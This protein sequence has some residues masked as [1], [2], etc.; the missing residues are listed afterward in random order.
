M[1]ESRM[2]LFR[3]RG[4]G[5]SLQIGRTGS[6]GNPEK[7]AGCAHTGAHIVSRLVALSHKS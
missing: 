2:G 5:K 6:A 7:I 4:F 3:V 1:F